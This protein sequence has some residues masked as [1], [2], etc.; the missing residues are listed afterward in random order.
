MPT[1]EFECKKCNRRFDMVIPFMDG[2]TDKF[3]PYCGGES[4][5]IYFATP[6]IY[7]TKGF[8]STDSKKG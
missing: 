8:Y 4:K 1:Y 6:T 5:R 7:K 2:L 3:C